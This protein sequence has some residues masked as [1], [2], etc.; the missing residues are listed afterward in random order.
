MTARLMIG[1]QKGPRKARNMLGVLKSTMGVPKLAS[2]EICFLKLASSC[3]LEQRS[4]GKP[5]SGV[6]AFWSPIVA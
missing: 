3:A 4:A 1:I 6:A 2:S 5:W